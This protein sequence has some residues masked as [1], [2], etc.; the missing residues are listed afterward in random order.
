MTHR[1]AHLLIQHVAITWN[2]SLRKFLVT[3]VIQR[4]RHVKWL[5]YEDSHNTW[6]PWKNLR[7]YDALHV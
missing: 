5:T 3:L 6:E 1:R 2:I 7:L 4:N